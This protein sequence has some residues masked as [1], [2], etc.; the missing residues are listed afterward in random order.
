MLPRQRFSVNDLAYPGSPSS[1]VG[2]SASSFLPAYDFIE[3]LM[4][5]KIVILIS[6]FLY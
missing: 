1:H 2:D 4:S 6:G 5:S 3:N